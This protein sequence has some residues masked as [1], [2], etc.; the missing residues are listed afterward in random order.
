MADYSCMQPLHYPLGLITP[1]AL[2]FILEGDTPTN[3]IG[4]TRALE[5]GHGSLSSGAVCAPP[6]VLHASAP[7]APC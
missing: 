2:Q 5:I 1:P 4:T 7:L 6:T 3:S